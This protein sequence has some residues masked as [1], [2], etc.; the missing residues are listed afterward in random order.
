MSDEKPKIDNAAAAADVKPAVD[1]K[2]DAGAHINIKVAS[3]VSS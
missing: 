2:K 3:S 1:D